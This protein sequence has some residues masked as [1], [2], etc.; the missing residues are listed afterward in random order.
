L[1]TS[2]RY[3]WLRCRHLKISSWI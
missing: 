3:S 2:V 1:F